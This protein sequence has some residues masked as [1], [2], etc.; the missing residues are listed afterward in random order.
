MDQQVLRTALAS[1]PEPT[2][3]RQIAAQLPVLAVWLKLASTRALL[4]TTRL[5]ENRIDEIEEIIA[6]AIICLAAAIEEG[7]QGS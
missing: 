1:S 2:G 5:E 4:R 6:T 3:H 7:R